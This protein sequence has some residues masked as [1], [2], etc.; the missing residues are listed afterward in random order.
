MKM[1]VEVDCTPEEARRFLGLP[2]VSAFNDALVKEM[3][4]NLHALEP[5]EVM[6]N[7]MSFGLGAQEQFAKLMQAGMQAA[8]VPTKPGE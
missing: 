6:K 7:W 5:A 3:Q 4:A 8:A 2:D 1:T